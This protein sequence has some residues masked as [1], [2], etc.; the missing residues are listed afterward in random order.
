[1]IASLIL[2]LQKCNTGA[3]SRGSLPTCKLTIKSSVVHVNE[4]IKGD[5]LWINNTTK[6]IRFPQYGEEKAVLR[7]ISGHTR[8]RIINL[9]LRDMGSYQ[10]QPY[11]SILPRSS[12]SV[13]IDGF[14]AISRRG[15][16]EIALVQ[17]RHV[18]G[19]Q[20]DYVLRFK[21]NWSKVQVS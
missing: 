17:I 21:T 11:W 15:T 8:G 9:V 6:V 3:I 2:L 7:S 10:S 18:P 20:K 14:Y 5:V 19:H 13:P 4:P 1:M 12:V 16:Y